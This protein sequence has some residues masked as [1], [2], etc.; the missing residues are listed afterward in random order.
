M[1]RE[2]VTSEII[3]AQ[4]RQLKMPGLTRSFES[5]ARKAKEE[6]AGHDEYLSTVLGAEIQSRTEAA[7]NNRLRAARFP[8]L[9][10]L[11]K[12]DFSKSEG[13]D[14][15]EIASLAK[16]EWIV[17]GRNVIFA[18]PIGTGK[19]HLAIGLGIEACRQLHHVRFWR[20]ADLVQALIEARDGR[21]LTRLQ[22]RLQQVQLLII[23]EL[24]FVPFDRT[25]GE[26]LFNVFAQR[27]ERRAVVITTN[28][29]FGEWPKVFGGDEKLTTALLD[30]LAE[31]ATVITPRGRSFR[32]RRNA[33]ELDA[34]K[35]R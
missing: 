30:R 25:G 10:T 35:A 9:K 26:L 1:S 32:M 5:L 7:M 33:V 14:A 28:L 2:I 31:H 29:A 34:K 6:R 22:R 23:D 24:G 8:E 11:D 13:V 15:K 19:T 12:F 20:A 4:A 16:G 18:G 21:E 17:P 3:R 27:H